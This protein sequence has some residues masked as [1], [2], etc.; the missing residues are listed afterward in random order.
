MSRMTD[1]VKWLD[2]SE[3]AVGMA[4]LTPPVRSKHYHLRRT[5]DWSKATAILPHPLSCGGAITCADASGRVSGTVGRLSGVFRG[6]ALPDR[7]SSR[8][9]IDA[10]CRVVKR[11]HSGLWIRFSR[12]ESWLG[13]RCQWPRVFGFLFLPRQSVTGDVV[14]L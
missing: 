11:Y 5:W 8:A 9:M 1:S 7:T 12:F 4:A 10:Y 3:T 13:S 2:R 6:F 14:A